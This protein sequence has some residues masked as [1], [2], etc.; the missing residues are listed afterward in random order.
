[1]ALFHPAS[2]RWADRHFVLTKSGFLHWFTS[3]EELEPLDALAL[4][5][6]AFESSSEDAT[7]TISE[8]QGGGVAHVR[9]HLLPL[10]WC[11]RRCSIRPRNL[12]HWAAAK[13]SPLVAGTGCGSDSVRARACASIASV[14]I[15]RDATLTSVR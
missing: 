5:R 10:R 1:M 15:M 7:I 3:A 11:I 14:G 4:H 2:R 9:P 13:L 8:V 12:E 6:C